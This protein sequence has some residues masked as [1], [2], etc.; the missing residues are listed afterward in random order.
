MP[1][2]RSSRGSRKSRDDKMG[3]L[4]LTLAAGALGLLA[5]F[6]LGS[7]DVR[8]DPDTGCRIGDHGAPPAH[9]MILIDQTDVL[10]QAEVGYARRL[11]TNE[12]HWLPEDGVLTV[13]S[14]KLDPSDTSQSITICRMPRGSE[15]SGFTMTPAAVQRDFDRMAGARLNRFLR[16]LADARPQ[17]GTPLM[18]A[19]AI[20]YRDPDFGADIG[21]R[22]LVILSD[23]IENSR[24]ADHYGRRYRTAA[25]LVPERFDEVRVD[26]ARAAVRIHYV[27][28]PRRSVQGVDHQGF[29]EDYFR[30]QGADDVA[31]GH[32]L[33]LGEPS[34]RQVWYGD[35]Q[36]R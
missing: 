32:A 20:T 28:R 9:T 3:C 18:E 33:T 14:I 2:R 6:G 4:L 5:Y 1:R 34:G 7:T 11:I 25:D 19:I 21:A 35:R 31:I 15:V 36:G 27:R 17:P 30:E 22:R 29:W 16:S 13:R 10:P 23:M 8:R 24:I 26:M 12:Y